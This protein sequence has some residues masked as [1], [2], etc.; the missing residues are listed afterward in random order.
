R[1]RGHSGAVCR[2]EFAGDGQTLVS[3]GFDGTIKV[4][5]VAHAN[6]S[7]GWGGHQ[8]RV[9]GLA[10]NKAG[11]QLVSTDLGGTVHCWRTL[12]GS[13]VREISSSPEVATARSSASGNTIAWK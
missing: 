6:Q 2:V 4:W 1:L 11:D 3:G 9:D 7:V 12:D 5:D 13:T 8:K 10:F